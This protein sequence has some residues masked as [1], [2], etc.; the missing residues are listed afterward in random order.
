MQDII[1]E[2]V[3]MDVTV[4]GK[5]VFTHPTPAGHTLVCYVIEG[6]GFF[7]SDHSLISEGK[8]V[9]FGDGQKIVVRTEDSPVRFLLISGKPIGEP[10]VWY[11]PIVMNTEEEIRTALTEYQSGKFIKS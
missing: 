9:Q 7:D 8:L 4:P 6:S 11:G 5:A 3:Y 1:T 2:P 10:V